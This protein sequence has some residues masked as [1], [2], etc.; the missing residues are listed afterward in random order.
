MLSR[1]FVSCLGVVAESPIFAE[2][3]RL[4]DFLFSLRCAPKH[5]TLHIRVMYER[6]PDISAE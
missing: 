2:L 1:L 6:S 3:V 5:V 4:A